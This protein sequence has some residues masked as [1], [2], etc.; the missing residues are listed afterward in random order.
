MNWKANVIA[1]SESQS[2]VGV[3]VQQT[4]VQQA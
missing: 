1:A 4:E 2:A 3:H